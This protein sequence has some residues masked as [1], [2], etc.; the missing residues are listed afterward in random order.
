M[1]QPLSFT[2]ISQDDNSI[3][4]FVDMTTG[5]SGNLPQW[6][7]LD[8]KSQNTIMDI[9]KNPDSVDHSCLVC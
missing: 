1:A 9:I 7:N 6:S 8:E 5:Q 2:I 4:S 3:L